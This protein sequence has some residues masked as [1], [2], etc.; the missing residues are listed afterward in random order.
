MRRELVDQGIQVTLL[1]H[2]ESIVLH[3]TIEHLYYNGNNR[4]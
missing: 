1:I 2:L 4:E 3:R